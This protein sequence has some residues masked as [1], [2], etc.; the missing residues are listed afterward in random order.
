[1]VSAYV[2]AQ[3]YVS[4]PRNRGPF[5]LKVSRGRLPHFLVPPISHPSDASQPQLASINSSQGPPQPKLRRLP[6]CLQPQLHTAGPALG[7]RAGMPAARPGRGS[8]AGPPRS[9]R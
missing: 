4:T 9:S 5:W 8:S 1:M 3:S 6:P 7:R 2:Y